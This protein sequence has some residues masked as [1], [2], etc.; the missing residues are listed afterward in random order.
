ML[1][2]FNGKRAKRGGGEEEKEGRSADKRRGVDRQKIN[3]YPN[4]NTAVELKEKGW[5]WG[6]FR[7]SKLWP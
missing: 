7:C 4:K 5:E 3:V 6:N 1:F 2:G